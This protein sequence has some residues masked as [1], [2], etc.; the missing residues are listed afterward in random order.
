MPLSLENLTADD[1]KWIYAARSGDMRRDRPSNYYDPHKKG[2]DQF[3]RAPH[4][5]R[6]LFPGNRWGKTTALG[7]EVN[8]YVT[9]N[10]RFHAIPTHKTQVMWFCVDFGQFEALQPQLHA[11]CFDAGYKYNETKH[12]YEWPGGELLV[13]SDERDWKNI[14]G[15]NPDLIVIDEECP[16][17]LFRELGARTFGDRD[18]R[19]IVGATATTMSG[20]WMEKELY[21]KWL[22][23]HL[24]M[25]LDERAAML[26]QRHP[27]IWC[28]PRGGIGDNP[29]MDEAKVS[30]WK[31]QTWA[32]EKEKKVRDE[33][34]FETSVGDPVFDPSGIDWLRRRRAELLT[35]LGE[36]RRGFF[37]VIEKE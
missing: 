37:E 30:R 23:L 18:T 1:A 24:G 13:K 3:H 29:S 7:V 21:R 14:Q 10:Q 26:E 25:G 34:G 16:L 19:I 36:G 6:A 12:I 20:S 8:C 32:S 33:G 22:D 28:W 15:T 4:R 5:T 17:E 35:E 31:A 27:E 2:Q 9:H 11:R